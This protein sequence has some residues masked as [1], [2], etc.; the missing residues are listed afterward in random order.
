MTE[1]DPTPSST[2]P[3]R[4]MSHVVDRH[5]ENIGAALR[6]I[7]L[8]APMWRVLN[9]LSEG[10]TGSIADLA[11]HAAFERSYVS[12]LVARMDELGLVKCNSDDMDRRY[13]SVTITAFGRKQHAKALKIVRGLNSQSLHDFSDQ[14]SAQLLELIRKIAKNV[15]VSTISMT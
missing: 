6:P 1:S 5:L 12:R 15:G 8:T 10:G 2:W 14:E 11:K 9:G 13:R 7:G 3:I 4:L